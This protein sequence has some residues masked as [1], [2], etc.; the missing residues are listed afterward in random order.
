MPGAE[1]TSRTWLKLHM[2]AISEDIDSTVIYP[3]VE[4]QIQLQRGGVRRS[5]LYRGCTTY[6]FAVVFFA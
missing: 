4:N 2:L 5:L 3:K 6:V 1:L